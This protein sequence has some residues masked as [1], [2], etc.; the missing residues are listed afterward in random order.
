MSYKALFFS[1][2][3]GLASTLTATTASAAYP[4]KPI[5]LIVPFPAGGTVDVMGRITAQILT[6]SLGASVVAENYGGAAG[7]IGSQMV[8]HA[9]P[10]GYTLLVGST[11]TLSI[12]PF[13]EKV[14]YDPIKD[15]TPVTLVAFVPHVLVINPDIPAHNLKEFIA[16]AK[17][18]PGKLSFGSSGIGTPHQ[19]A[20]EMFNEM[21]GLDLLHVPYRGTAPALADLMAGRIA[22]MSAELDIALPYIQAGKLRVLGIATPERN[23]VAP[24]IPTVSEAGL[25]GY[26]VMSWYGIVAPAGTPKAN[27]QRLAKVIATRLEQPDMQDKLHKLGA[28]PVGGSPES[29]ATFLRAEKLKWGAVIAKSGA[30]AQ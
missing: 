8:A 21:T 27:V 4:D 2:A 16:Y 10:D 30:K 11:S 14:G 22:F 3:L 5:R 15:F 28:T 6:E 24:Q 7:A 13:F 29:F 12:N 18:H 17:Q 1:L 25:P 26:Q 20:G 23:A 19:I 9:K